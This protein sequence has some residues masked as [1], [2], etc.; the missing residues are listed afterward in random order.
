MRS[1][2]QAEVIDAFREHP[3][4]EECVIPD[5]LANLALAIERRRGT[6]HRIG[7]DQHFADIGEG[8]VRAV[9]NLEQLLDFAE[10]GH[11]MGDVVH[12]LRVANP[13]LLSIVPANEFNKQLLQRVRFRNHC[14]GP[15][16][17]ASKA[18]FHLLRDVLSRSR[19]E[20][21]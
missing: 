5:V 6:V 3:R 20:R 7:L 1:A 12:D 2:A 4:K 11:E 16:N 8:F 18:E 10:L 14:S 13:N 15:P 9:A 19:Q 21:K 17:A